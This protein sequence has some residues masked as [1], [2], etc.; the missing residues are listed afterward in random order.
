MNKIV[1]VGRR[2]REIVLRS[3][4]TE[5]TE[6]VIS[7]CKQDN[8]NVEYT[9]GVVEVQG[10]H[11]PVLLSVGD[12]MRFLFQNGHWTCPTFAYEFLQSKVMHQLYEVRLEKRHADVD[13]L[14]DKA[15]RTTPSERD[16]YGLKKAAYRKGWLTQ[17]SVFKTQ[18]MQLLGF[19]YRVVD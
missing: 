11:H 19:H 13:A 12:S 17:L 15:W 10:C 2:D 1:H 18:E 5:G 14:L 3:D 4:A 9:P 7:V 8:G 16:Y 6:R